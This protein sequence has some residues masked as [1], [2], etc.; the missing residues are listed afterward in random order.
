[1]RFEVPVRYVLGNQI[2][3][4]SRRAKP[5]P[6]ETFIRIKLEVFS[7]HKKTTLNGG[8]NMPCFCH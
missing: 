8:E 4:I 5:Q 1:M 3:N 2:Q 6:L 7:H